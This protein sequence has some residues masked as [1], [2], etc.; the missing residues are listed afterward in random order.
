MDRTTTLTQLPTYQDR[1]YWLQIPTHSTITRT[2]PQLVDQH[3]TPRHIFCQHRT[4]RLSLSV[5]APLVLSIQTQTH[6]RISC[7]P[8]AV[9]TVSGAS[10]AAD[11]GI[12]L[13]CHSVEWLWIRSLTSPTCSQSALVPPRQKKEGKATLSQLLQEMKHG[14]VDFGWQLQILQRCWKQTSTWTGWGC[15]DGNISEK[16]TLRWIVLFHVTLEICA[17]HQ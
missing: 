10:M 11:P 14:V 8:P 17:G 13:R 4:L 2:H 15:W 16:Q 12:S 3:F 1:S 5:H 6:N 9:P 7:G